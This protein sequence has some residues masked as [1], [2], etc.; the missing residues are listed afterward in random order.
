MKLLINLKIKCHLHINIKPV[1]FHSN[2]QD[3]LQPMVY[4]FKPVTTQPLHTTQ[5]FNKTCNNDEFLL[6]DLN[7]YT[8][9]KIILL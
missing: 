1:C 3:N 2:T 4:T 5:F 7:Q 8:T 6:K 9:Y